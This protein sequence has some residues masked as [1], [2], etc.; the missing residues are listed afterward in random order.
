MT[1]PKGNDDNK[2]LLQTVPENNSFT[3][4]EK[5]LTLYLKALVHWISGSMRGGGQIHGIS[6]KET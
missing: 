3:H 4:K 1:H 5:L 2:G 6:E